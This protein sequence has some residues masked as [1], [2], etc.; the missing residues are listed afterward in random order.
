MAELRIPF[1]E[2]HSKNALHSFEHGAVGAGEAVLHSQTVHADTQESSPQDSNTAHKKLRG[3]SFRRS[4]GGTFTFCDLSR[5]GKCHTPPSRSDN[6]SQEVCDD[7][8]R[9]SATS[10]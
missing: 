5:G 9:R 3:L 1:E 10:P 8:I 4:S 7:N 2:I 6:T